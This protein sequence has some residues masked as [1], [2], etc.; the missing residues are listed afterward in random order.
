MF[1]EV[2]AMNLQTSIVLIVCAFL[3]GISAG[4]FVASLREGKKSKGPRGESQASDLIAMRKDQESGALEVVIAGQAFRSVSEMNSVQ[5]TLAGYAAND[6]KTWLN[7]QAASDR[8]AV[9]IIPAATAAA[10]ATPVTAAETAIEPS[11]AEVVSEIT[12]VLPT[13]APSGQAVDLGQQSSVPAEVEG[14]KDPKKVKRG[15]FMGVI[16][17]ALGTDVPSNR[18]VTKSIA[19]QVNEILQKK[20]K[21]TPLESRG[22]G[23]FELPGQEMV[24][25][26]GLDKYESVNAVPDDEIRA[27]LQSAVNEWL[28]RSS[29]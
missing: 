17:R 12:P 14:G 10:T 19:A 15:G 11:T 16:T 1:F 6:L 5:R 3:L 9:N 28:A 4:G 25:M 20:L 8:I 29:T 21:D 27:V 22:I 18:Q 23:L 7:P 24:V 13:N 2:T 26:I